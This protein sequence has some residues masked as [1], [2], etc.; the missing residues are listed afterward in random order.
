MENLTIEKKV[1]IELTQDE[2]MRVCIGLF[3]CKTHWSNEAFKREKGSSRDSAVHL[4]QEYV[5]LLRKLS[6]QLEA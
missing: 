3:D 1:T 5:T 6:K 4:R 2:L